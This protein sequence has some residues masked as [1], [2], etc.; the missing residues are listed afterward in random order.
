MKKF[1]IIMVSITA[2]CLIAAVVLTAV[3]QGNNVWD[4]SRGD[5]ENMIEGS[6]GEVDQ[7]QTA[8]LS[9]KGESFTV[10]VR[11]SSDNIQVH[12][13]DEGEVRVRFHGTI[14]S[15]RRN[16]PVPTLRM[17]ETAHGVSFWLDNTNVTFV[18][19]YSR[20]TV[21]DVYLPS[22]YAG[23]LDLNA[24]SGNIEVGGYS[25][26]ELKCDA[27]SGN[28]VINDVDADSVSANTSS[29][30][31]KA[32]GI[33]GGSFIAKA[34]SGNI[35]GGDIDADTIDLETSS[36]DMRLS[37]V[38]GDIE[39][40]A[41]SGR[42]GIEEIGGS[43]KV[44]AEASSGDIVMTFTEMGMDL[45]FHTSS[46]AVKLLFPSDAA[47]GINFDTSSGSFHSD[48]PV[49]MTK[50]ERNSVEGYVGSDTN[51]VRVQTSSG[52]CRIN[53]R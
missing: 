44:D 43:G 40:N 41:S 26:N 24:S 23:D 35:T 10:T 31:I 30:N 13:G 4:R 37:G 36:G 17:E 15:S 33:G 49:T 48:F 7:T 42:I 28:V 51:S 19:F 46:G 27:S 21:M 16:I 25:L 20:N 52:D 50:S 12:Y 11:S 32:D 47:F 1:V 39:A 18:G 34:T 14:R 22:S 2:V 6:G 38:S 45:R 3:N 9:G 5:W 29:G 8:S 53:T